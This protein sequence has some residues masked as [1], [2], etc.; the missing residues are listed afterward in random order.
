MFHRNFGIRQ[1][2]RFCEA[3]KAVGSLF[4]DFSRRLGEEVEFSDAGKF[5]ICFNCKLP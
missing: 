4:I 3:N 1:G 5:V 2:T